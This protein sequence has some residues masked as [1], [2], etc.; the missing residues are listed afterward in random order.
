MDILARDG[1]EVAGSASADD[2]DASS[3]SKAAVYI[4]G[5]LGISPDDVLSSDQC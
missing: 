2:T 5:E 3:M 1:K 4:S